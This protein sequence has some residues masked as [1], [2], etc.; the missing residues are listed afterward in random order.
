MHFLFQ[1]FRIEIKISYWIQLAFLGH[2]CLHDYAPTYLKN[3]FYSRSSH[4]NCS[5][6]VFTLWL[7]KLRRIFSVN[8]G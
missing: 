8:P 3:L 7:D 5:H 6:T 2:K 4:R 1:K